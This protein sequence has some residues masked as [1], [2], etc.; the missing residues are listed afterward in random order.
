[1]LWKSQIL[2]IFKT[3]TLSVILLVLVVSIQA[4]LCQGLHL[5]LHG[6]IVN[7]Y[8]HKRNVMTDVNFSKRLVPYTTHLFESRTA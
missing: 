6:Q 1:L 8:F 2:E 7:D 5:W 4:S 3:K